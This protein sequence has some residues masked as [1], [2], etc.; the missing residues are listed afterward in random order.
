MAKSIITVGCTLLNFIQIH[1]FC[2]N[3]IAEHISEQLLEFGAEAVTFKDAA[4]Q[5]IYEPAPG[6]TPTLWPETIITGLFN[7]TQVLQP[8]IEYFEKQ[9]ASGAIQNFHKEFL[10]DKDWVRSSLD[11][12]KPLHI[13]KTLC[14]CPSWIK[15]PSLPMINVMLDPGLAFGTGTHPTTELCLEWLECHPMTP[16]L[17]AIDYGCGS[18]ILGIAALKLGAGKVIAIDYDPQAL[19]ATRSNAKLNNLSL[20]NLQTCLPSDIPSIKADLLMAN[21]L[22][23][24][25]ITLAPYFVNLLKENGK[26]ILSGILEQQA[27]KIVEI[28]HPWFNI[29]TQ[30]SRDGW[31]FIEG[32]K[33]K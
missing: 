17:Q 31:V 29:E 21:I 18:G 5:P 30:I 7:E 25:L 20:D 11:N 10:P 23:Q 12:F 19:I 15:P 2:G 32:T 22:A 13:G 8:I 14:I 6:T 33:S 24:P 26:I 28:Y 3:K 1:I 16:S 4:N 9:Q 27:A